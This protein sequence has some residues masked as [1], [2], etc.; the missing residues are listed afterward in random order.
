MRL[1][2]LN[3]CR[4]DHSRSICGLAFRLASGEV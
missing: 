2:V 4:G 1:Q 3:L